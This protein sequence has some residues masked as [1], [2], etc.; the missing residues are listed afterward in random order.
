MDLVDAPLPPEQ[1]RALLRLPALSE[2][3]LELLV[4]ELQVGHLLFEPDDG[5]LGHGPRSVSGL[6]EAKRQVLFD[7]VG[8][9]GTHYHDFAQGATALGA[10][11]L[12]EMAFASPAAEDFAVGGEFEAFSHALSGF[13]T[14]GPSHENW[15]LTRL[16]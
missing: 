16:A 10:L 2:F 14:L 15:R 11:A 4:G 3:R 13:N 8:V 1:L 5:V 9:G 12:E 6:S 7:T